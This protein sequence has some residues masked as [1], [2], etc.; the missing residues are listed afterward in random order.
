[1]NDVLMR[2]R[3]ELFLTATVKVAVGPKKEIRTVHTLVHIPGAKG[4]DFVVT[5]TVKNKDGEPVINVTAEAGQT[6]IKDKEKASRVAVPEK[7]M[8][9]SFDNGPG[10]SA[11]QRA[12]ILEAAKLKDPGEEV[13]A[14]PGQDLRPQD[15][16]HN[17]WV[18]VARN[19]E[20]LVR[21]YTILKNF[22]EQRR[23]ETRAQAIQAL[24]YFTRYNNGAVQNA[25]DLRGLLTAA[26][27]L[28]SDMESAVSRDQYKASGQSGYF[29]EMQDIKDFAPVLKD[30][31]RVIDGS[32][33]VFQKKVDLL[34]LISVSLDAAMANV[35]QDAPP[36]SPQGLIYEPR[37]LLTQA[38]EYLLPTLAW[39]K[40]AQNRTEQ[41]G[42]AA[43]AEAYRAEF[44]GDPVRQGRQLSQIWVTR[45][46]SEFKGTESKMALERGL[47]KMFRNVLSG[48]N[49]GQQ[50]AF[51]MFL[52]AVTD[53][54]QWLSQQS[55]NALFEPLDGLQNIHK[56]LGLD[57]AMTPAKKTK[58]VAAKPETILIWADRRQQQVEVPTDVYER[59]SGVLKDINDNWR[60]KDRIFE[61]L[62]SM[63]FKRSQ[64]EMW[65]ASYFA[66]MLR[67]SDLE[68]VFLFLAKNG[69]I[70]YAG[71]L[72][73]PV[74]LK[75]VTLSDDTVSLIV[76]A[77]ISSQV[78]GAGEPHYI[79]LDPKVDAAM[80][81]TPGGID[82]A[83]SNLDMQIRRDGAGVPLP[84]SQ[85]NL[86]GIK[87]DGLVPVILDI[88]PA[89]SMPLFA[90]LS[91][92]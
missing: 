73:D 42:N 53:Q 45:I 21:Y 31:A 65:D 25:D 12:K 56:A 50:A 32:F 5:R 49:R 76:R 91:G 69:I 85:Q 55:P 60:D 39:L 78:G 88:K 3:N 92:G 63:S 7:D 29:P 10:Q 52:K 61:M 58:G 80:N 68:Q 27:S 72:K 43:W 19:P 57:A 67:N 41:D 26:R 89:A 48:N 1:M 54:Y 15:R 84:V 62:R 81:I 64:G 33:L 8:I 37:A 9:V 79:F 90:N 87:I 44:A 74:G 82:F 13:V 18:K 28:A 35:E 36:F 34:G 59:I 46:V 83:Q 86:D 4:S 14:V 11:E 75:S 47:Q 2:W 22:Y 30:A 70:I 38:R 51:L 71:D 20:I 77:A 40:H 66:M 17:H 6:V 24:L 23:I 16:L